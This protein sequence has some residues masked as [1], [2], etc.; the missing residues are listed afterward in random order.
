MLKTSN[1]FLTHLLA[2]ILQLAL[3]STSSATTLSGTVSLPNG[4]VATEEL[5][6]VVIIEDPL[7]S[8]SLGIPIADEVSIQPG[9]S[10]VNYSI[11]LPVNAS[12]LSVTIQCFSFSCRDSDYI[13]YYYLTEAGIVSTNNERLSDPGIATS[14]IPAKLDVT[15]ERGRTISGTLRLPDNIKPTGEVKGRLFIE[16]NGENIAASLFNISDGQRSV[17]FVFNSVPT[18]TIDRPYQIKYFCIECGIDFP[19]RDI[20]LDDLVISNYVNNVTLV[21]PTDGFVIAGTVTLP[22]DKL[23]LGRSD[24]RYFVVEYTIEE[25]GGGRRTYAVETLWALQA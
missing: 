22:I 3:S 23:N 20:L 2:V 13:R 15:L 11:D 6:I 18:N 4:E 1:I 24:A 9:S 17:P 25:L 8:S 16:L 12:S 7:V 21:L 10:S 19:V 14:S 5:K